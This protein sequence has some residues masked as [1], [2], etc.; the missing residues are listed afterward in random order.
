MRLSRNGRRQGKR[1]KCS[2]GLMCVEQL[3]K[4]FMEGQTSRKKKE[5]AA[6]SSDTNILTT[7]MTTRTVQR[8][9]DPHLKTRLLDGIKYGDD[10]S[11]VVCRTLW[12]CLIFVIKFVVYLQ[13]GPPSH[14]W[15]G[16]LWAYVQSGGG[17]G[18]NKNSWS[19]L[20]NLS[21]R[22]SSSSCRVITIKAGRVYYGAL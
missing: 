17:G 3:F 14:V 11:P 8:M 10:K 22:P 20:V 18:G 7:T 13:H 6:S 5:K 2:R 4:R 1:E 21:V 12:P 15:G 16:L 19:R 9:F